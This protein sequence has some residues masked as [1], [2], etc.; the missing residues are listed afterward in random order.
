MP[1]L[2]LSP[3]ALAEAGRAMHGLARRLYPICRSLTGNGVRETLEI[4]RERV[5]I[6]RHEVPTGTAAFDWTVPREWNVR[7]AWIARP[8]GERLVDFRRHNLH[9]VGYSTPVRG[10]FTRAELEPHLHSMPDHPDWIPYRTSYYRESWGFCLT[11]HQRT[12]LGEGPFEVVVDTTLAD[13]ALSYGELLLPG[14][15]PGEVLLSTHICHPA[16]A[17]DNLSGIAVLAALAELLAAAQNRYSY[18]LLF[19]PGTIGAITWLARNQESVGAIGAGLVAAGLGDRGPFHYKRSRRGN[20]EVDRAAVLALRDAGVEHGVS[21]FEPFGY[22]ERQF[23]S[24]GFDLPVGSL[25][26]RP[27]GTYAEY[28][29]SGDDLGFIAPES[30]A[31]SLGLYLRVIAALEGNRRYRNLNPK[32]EPQ[33]G[34][35]GLYSDLGGE[36]RG[37][38]ELALLWVLNYSDGEHDLLEIATRSKLPFEAVRAAA[39]ALEKAGLLQ[40]I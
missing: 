23:C 33:L 37:R 34:R 5:P 14:R 39:E 21:D 35:R 10:S 6:E 17:N 8:G 24:P 38:H 13:G 9:L 3:D 11:E 27:Y 19:L 26:R 25:T 18:R 2:A 16:L 36:H 40:Q 4:L 32:C 20:S 30:L 1:A 7:D 31:A 22:D 28:H 15:E 12:A 29:S